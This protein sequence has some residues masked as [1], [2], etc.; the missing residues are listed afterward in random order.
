MLCVLC[1][2]PKFGFL[3]LGIADLWLQH[4]TPL[5][6]LAV[7]MQASFESPFVAAASW[8]QH[9]NAP[10]LLRVFRGVSKPRT[11]RAFFCLGIEGAMLSS[12]G[13]RPPTFLDSRFPASLLCQ[14][15]WSSPY[16]NFL[17]LP[18]VPSLLVVIDLHHILAIFGFLRVPGLL[19]VA[20]ALVGLA[21]LPETLEERHARHFSLVA[22]TVHHLDDRK[23]ES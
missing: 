18:R 19:V 5:H 14:P 8:S 3:S 11:V 10:V 12:L 21:L 6:Q 2:V 20:L 23:S 13:T 7:E 1:M 15:A 22:S 16:T 17:A 4:T 9:A